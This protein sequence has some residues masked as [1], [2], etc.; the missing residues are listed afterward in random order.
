MVGTNP[1]TAGYDGRSGEGYESCSPKHM[2]AYSHAN[3][4]ILPVSKKPSHVAFGQIVVTKGNPSR[5][6]GFEIAHFI[7]RNGD[8]RSLSELDV[9]LPSLRKAAAWVHR[10]YPDAK[11]V[12]RRK[13]HFGRLAALSF[14]CS[15]KELIP[16][17][18]LAK[19]ALLKG[20][21]L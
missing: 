20:G 4:Q 5:G 19:R 16:G 6:K 3:G 14:E 10:Y 9:F 2:I 1:E 11:L 21:S 17:S 18:R 13:D 15:L 8:V 7:R 12:T